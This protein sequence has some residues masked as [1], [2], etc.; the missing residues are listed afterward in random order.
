MTFDHN[1]LIGAATAAHQVEG[2]NIHSD[3]W[4]LENMK[5]TSFSEP[6]GIAD[7]EYNRYE[8]DITY[9]ADA[10]LNAYRFS[11]EWARIEPEEGKFDEA[12]IEHYRKEI[13]FCKKKGIEPVVTLLHFTSPKWLIEKGGWEADSTITYFARYVHKVIEELG[14][15]LKYV[16]TINEANMGVQL[17][18][19][20]ERYRKQMMAAAQAQA[21]DTAKKMEGTAQVGLNLDK[22]LAGRKFQAAEN[23]EVFGTETPQTFVSARTAHGMEIVM[24]AHQAAVQEIHSLYPQIKAG[25]TLSLHE[26]RSQDGGEEKA[27]KAWGDEFTNWLPYIQNDDF[28]GV[29]NYTY[30][31]YNKD[32]QMPLPEGTE[33]TEM[34]Y[35]YAPEALGNVIRNVSKDFKGEIL[36]TENGI[37][38]KDDN[39]RQDF[40]KSALAGV[41]ACVHEGIPVKGYFHWSLLDNFEWQKGFAMTFGLIGVDR[42]TLARTPRRSLKLLGSY[43]GK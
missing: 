39:R 38:T 11:I 17:A 23:K 12:E 43:C 26:I 22:I 5:Y 30:M 37:C 1:F 34:G 14:S 27:K 41:Q 33:T 35:A 24:K 3:D 15:D 21:S 36:V 10:G 32:G 7:D 28:L 18:A 20:A 8:E 4:A 25:I 31:I 6:S 40:I 42:K 13:A 19:I 2:N 9:L 29:Q 16:C